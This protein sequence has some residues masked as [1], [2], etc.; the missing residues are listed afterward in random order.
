[1]GDDAEGER[2]RERETSI[3]CLRYTTVS[4]YCGMLVVT[5]VLTRHFI[6]CISAIYTR[7]LTVCDWYN[8]DCC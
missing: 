3:S 2:E 8:T 6:Y 4:M 5:A 7:A 1:M